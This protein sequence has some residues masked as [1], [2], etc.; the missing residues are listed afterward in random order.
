MKIVFYE[1][2]FWKGV[3]S[4]KQ[5]ERK[6]NGHKVK[7]VSGC[8]SPENI[9]EA[10]DADAVCL[11]VFSKIGKKELKIWKKCKV[12]GTMST[13]YN[14]INLRE[15]KKRK[16]S[17]CNVPTYGST[18]V[19]EYTI[20]MMLALS[21][22]IVQAYDKARE[23]KFDLHG[24]RGVD[25]EGKTLGIVGFGKIGQNVATRASAF[26]MKILAYDPYTDMQCMG[27]RGCIK[28]KM[29]ELLRKSDFISLHTPLLESTCHIIDR[30]AIKKMKKGVMIINTARGELIDTAAL[31][32]G[33][34]SGKIAGVAIDVI[35]EENVLK[36][37]R[38][39]FSEHVD[40]GK[41]N[42]KTV[43]ANH[44]LID[45]ENAIVT[46]HNAFNSKEAVARIVNA[47]I[48]NVKSFAKKKPSNVVGEKKGKK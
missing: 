12:I 21:R 11:F 25:V 22:K 10:K 47:T 24:L 17:I 26:G 46:S 23:G 8:V 48:E 16:I 15:C 19:A 28:A 43:V 7:F 38:K 32:D 36:N 1:A 42:M 45:M 3:Y 9:S 4:H 13:G 27:E 33:L 31:V 2:D 34:N 5:V 30:A 29:D 18:T 20:A 14:H 37:E 44:I 41:A 39:L 40:D 6:L 35:E